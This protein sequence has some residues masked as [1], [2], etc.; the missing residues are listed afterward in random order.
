MPLLVPLSGDYVHL[1][2]F[3]ECM[4][5]VKVVLWDQTQRVVLLADF[6]RSSFVFASAKQGH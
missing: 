4:G 1:L 5:E 6:V 2:P 3:D